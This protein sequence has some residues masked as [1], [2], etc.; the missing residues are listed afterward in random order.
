LVPSW[1]LGCGPERYRERLRIIGDQRFSRLSVAQP[2]SVD[3][4]LLERLIADSRRCAPA[5]EHDIL[6]AGIL[7]LRS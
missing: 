1:L 5:D 3:S 2:K 6:D 4:F 7:A